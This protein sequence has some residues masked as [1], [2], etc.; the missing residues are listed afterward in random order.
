MK[1][2]IRQVQQAALEIMRRAAIDIPADYKTG[3]EELQKS[4]TGKLS[5]FVIHTMLENWQAASEDRRPM[6]ADTGLPRYYVKAGNEASVESGFVALEQALRQA[7]AD[8]TQL[9]PLR[10]N[11]VHPLWRTDNGNNVGINAPEVEW[12]FEPEADWIDITTVHKGGLFGTDYRMLFPGDGIAGIKR[13]V[14]DTLIAFG[15]RGLACQPAIIGIGLG[16]SKDSCMQ[17][18]KQAACLR[19]VGDRN[20]DPKI[21]DLEREL[22]TLGN[23]IG[24]GAM[25]FVG[26]SMV[27]DCHIEVGHTHTGGMP[28]SMH[29]FCLSSRRATARIHPDGSIAYRTDPQ[30]FTPYHR[31]ESIAW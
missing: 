12:S 29:S 5:R 28:I 30:W 27:V 16:G 4:E 19:V 10:P 9:V 7:T 13:F 24:M 14:L 8:A 26:S 17:L 31:R 11:R 3:I 1:I 2:P 18:G 25:G 6:C 20:P 22:K 23:A 15:K 21:A